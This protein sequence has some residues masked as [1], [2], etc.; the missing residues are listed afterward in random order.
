MPIGKGERKVTME[1]QARQASTNLPFV[2]DL[3][4]PYVWAKIVLATEM[5]TVLAIKAL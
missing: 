3:M 1:N 2:S 5:L 4:F